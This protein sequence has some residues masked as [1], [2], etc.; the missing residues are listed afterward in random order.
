M[1]PLLK[2]P[3]G[4]RRT[5]AYISSKIGAIPDNG[6][7]IELFAGSA[8]VFFYMEPTRAVLVDNC[9]PLISFYEGLK[10][11]PGMFLNELDLLLKLPHSE[12]TY[13]AIKREWNGHDFGPKFAARLMY[14]N[15]LGFNGLFRLNRE[16]GYNVAWGK[17]AK[18]P[19]FPDKFAIN[20][21][22]A[23]LADVTLYCADYSIVLRSAHQDDVIYAD[24]PYYGTYDRYSG[25]GFGDEEH[26][27]LAAGL[28]AAVQ[29]GAHVFASNIDCPEVRDMYSDF[30]SIDVVPV[31]HKIGCTTE[32]RKTVNEV[33][34]S[35]RAPYRD[36][37]Q[38]EMPV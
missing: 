22:A 3:G 19:K 12:E 30:A 36:P 31:L 8:A 11:E 20:K 33:F 26:R 10:R 17:K 2:W 18:Q 1:D 34:M 23:L 35:A 5:A 16:L 25:T 4:K 38:V 15:K 21:A 29:R 13:N 37:R 14:L 7:Y 9:K 24:P 32:S 27:K 6:R 28:R